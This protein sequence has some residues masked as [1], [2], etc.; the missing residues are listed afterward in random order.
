MNR[1]KAMGY[2]QQPSSS[3]NRP[4]PDRGGNS[5]PRRG[6]SQQAAG[7]RARAMIRSTARKNGGKPYDCD[8]MG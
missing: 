5:G 7:A 3:E 2:P 4:A 6:E 8:G 1:S